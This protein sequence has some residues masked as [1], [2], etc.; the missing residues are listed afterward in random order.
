MQKKYPNYTTKNQEEINQFSNIASE[1]WNPTGKFKPLHQINPVR[2]Q[3]IQNK[4]MQHFQC[5]NHDA[6]PFKGLRILDLG[7]GGGLLSEPIARMGA[8]V[9]GIDPSP[10]NIATAKNHAD[11]HNINIDYR[12]ACAEDIAKTDE[13]FDV[14]LNMEVIEH[15]N[16]IHYFANTCCSLLLDD[17]L[18]FVSTINRTFKA[19]LLAIVGAEYVL[20]WLPKGT[21]QYEKFV[22]PIEI[23]ELLA[24]NNVEVIDRIGL[25]Y[26]ILCNK[27]KLSEK[28]M[29]VNYMLL[30]H[31]P[32]IR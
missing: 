19:M 18:M 11:T 32:K 12:V 24:K 25:V 4:I 26:S 20:Q 23:E 1:W 2:L 17:G 6:Y 29:D 22:K 3:Y 16:N 13:K 8:T 28:N 10:K 7:C 31:L 15:V 21:H 5:D 14:I 30:A 27:W 9:I